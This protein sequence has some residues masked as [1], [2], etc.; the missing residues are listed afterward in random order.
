MGFLFAPQGIILKFIDKHPG[1]PRAP[2]LY[3]TQVV[4]NRPGLVVVK[5]N[6]SFPVSFG[7][8][9]VCQDPSRPIKRQVISMPVPAG[10][11]GCTSAK[12]PWSSSIIEPKVGA[13]DRGQQLSFPSKVH[14]TGLDQL[15]RAVPI[16]TSQILQQSPEEAA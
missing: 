6:V 7:E 16:A 1:A 8:E 14:S 11:T 5:V 13:T 9:G 3:R 4:P 15:L 2:P 12:G 10:K